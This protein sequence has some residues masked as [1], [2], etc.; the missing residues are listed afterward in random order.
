MIT[1]IILYV[2]AGQRTQRT[3]RMTP[4]GAGAAPYPVLVH[5]HGGGWVI[6]NPNGYDASARALA[7]AAGAVVVSVAYRQAPEAP[8]AVPHAR[9]AALRHRPAEEHRQ[10]PPGSWAWKRPSWPPGNSV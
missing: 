8:S 1:P 6:A 9:H 5:F 4:P 3:W 10:P 7:N 2:A